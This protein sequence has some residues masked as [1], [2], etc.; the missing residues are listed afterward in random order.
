MSQ[1]LDVVVL[2]RQP[3]LH[4]YN[5]QGLRAVSCEGEAIRLNPLLCRAIAGDFDGDTVAVHRPVDPYAQK[6]AWEKLRPAV[7]LR[8]SAGGQPL[9]KL[10][11]D[12]ALGIRLLGATEQGRQLL[13]QHAAP[14]PDANADALSARI[15]DCLNLGREPALRCLADLQHHGFS[16]ATGWSVG[17]LDLSALDPV[18]AFSLDTAVLHE[19]VLAAIHRS[20]L[21]DAHAVEAVGGLEALVQVLGVRRPMPGFDPRLVKEDAPPGNMWYGLP[22]DLYFACV[23][24]ALSRLAEKKL[25]TSYAGDLTKSLVEACYDVAIGREDC[26]LADSRSP[27]TC[28]DPNPCQRCYGPDPGTGELLPLGAQVGIRAGML[29]GERG[30]QL[31]MKTFHGGGTGVAVGTRLDQLWGL[32]GEGKFEWNG[33]PTRLAGLFGADTVAAL[34]DQL[35]AT[36]QRVTEGEIASVH[37]AVVLRRL[38][39]VFRS[40]SGGRGS[41]LKRASLTNRPLVDATTRGQLGSFLMGGKEAPS[42]GEGKLALILG[43]TR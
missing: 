26:G 1:Y 5:L 22:D 7:N 24:G 8:S 11:L 13:S 30:T 12:V 36:F 18:V 27:L 28:R 41:L 37:A 42:G 31:A 25:T 33:K 21:V 14:Y 39:E 29:I 43:G 38:W 35:L 32:F 10:D 15:G 23:N 17:L 20:P 6:E 2:N 3:S 34:G 40:Q 19:Q 9:A 16:A 4:P